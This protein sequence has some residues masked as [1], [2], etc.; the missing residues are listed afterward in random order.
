[1]LNVLAN[2]FAHGVEKLVLGFTPI[3]DTGFTIN[4]LHLDDAHFFVLQGK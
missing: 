3:D 4:E 1:M 2:I